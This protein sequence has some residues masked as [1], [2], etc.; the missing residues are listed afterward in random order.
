M[1]ILDFGNT[2]VLAFSSTNIH[3]FSV[4]TFPVVVFFSIGI[5]S[6]GIFSISVFQNTILNS[7]LIKESIS[8]T[9]Q[10]E[11]RKRLFMFDSDQ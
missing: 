4:T 10:K 2:A 11:S 9:K 7:L 8:N 1:N 5:S 6:P 3:T